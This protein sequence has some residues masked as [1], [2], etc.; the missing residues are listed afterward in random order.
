MLSS[1]YE[2]EAKTR[3]N[4]MPLL[5]PPKRAPAKTSSKN[6]TSDDSQALE[7]RFEQLRLTNSGGWMVLRRG[8]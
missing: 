7:E 4:T 8:S 2:Q 3:C 6:L 5:K 1:E